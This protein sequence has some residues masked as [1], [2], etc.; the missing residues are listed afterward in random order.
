MFKCT[1][2]RDKNGCTHK[3]VTGLPLYTNTASQIVTDTMR[4]WRGMY[5]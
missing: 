2:D 1:P 3:L 4:L 5:L